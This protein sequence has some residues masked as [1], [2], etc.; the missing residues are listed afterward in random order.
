MCGLAGFLGP[1]PFQQN[2]LSALQG[3][4][5]SLAHRGPDDEG[6]WL[7]NM[8]L[9]GLAH[10]RLS[11]LDLSQEGHQPKFSSHGRYVMAYNGEIY[12]AL[13]LRQKWNL[14][15]K[16]HSDTLILLAAIEA[17]GIEAVLPKLTG[18][19]ALALWDVQEQ[20]LWLVRD[21]VGIKPLYYGFFAG[22]L[23]FASELRALQGLTELPLNID[24]D[25]LGLLLRHNAIGAQHS[26][27]KDIK[28]LCPGHYIRLRS[29]EAPVPQ[30]WWSAIEVAKSSMASPFE[31]SEAEAVLELEKK[32]LHSVQIHMA[33]DVPLGAFLSGGIDSSLV[34]ALAQKSSSS[35]LKTF[36]IGL[37]EKGYNEAEQAKAISQHLGTEHHE[38]YLDP[39]Q[40]A[41]EVP[42]LLSR[43]DEPFADSSFIPTAC[44]ARMT[45]A[46][47]TVSLSGDGGDELFGGYSRYRWTE[48][49]WRKINTCPEFI[50]PWLRKLMV[51]LPPQRWDQVWAGLA[52]FISAP[53]THMGQK[54]HRL[55]KLMEVKSPREVYL[56]MASHFDVPTDWVTRSNNIYSHLHDEKVWAI[57]SQLQEQMMLGDFVAY[58]PDDIL[59]KV[60]R[61]TMLSSLEARVPLLTPELFAFA[62]S[63]PLEMR[64]NKRILKR[65]LDRHIPREM[66]DRPKM[67]FG[68]PI[69]QWLR[70]PLR[71]WAED[72]LTEDVLKKGDFFPVL[73]VRK[74]WTEH[75]GGK[76]D[77]EY[78]LW[79]ILCFQHW[80][81]HTHRKS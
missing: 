17:L 68:I 29:G 16:G 22:A 13:E 1:W 47:V 40:M 18:M 51:A 30:C 69:G 64:Q 24:R 44:V 10:R 9:V 73:A 4:A 62:W 53:E 20:E 37:R 52:K 70:G 58:L 50:R 81:I 33:A 72:L 77:W 74:M 41:L 42:E 67:G 63:L 7:E 8:G 76:F 19:F 65:V 11:I 80:L 32:L 54:M 39:E 48:S 78:Y 14:E 23:F 34:C 6:V 57:S 71:A 36:T 59:T 79:D 43:C 15:V 49:V 27:Y 5:Q 38:L 21:Q 2:P 26:I 75:L 55:A 56:K 45:R 31:G 28:K 61:A 35:P 3:M 46:H 12:N 60:D 66:M 25:A